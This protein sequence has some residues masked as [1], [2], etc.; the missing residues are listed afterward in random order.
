MTM[1]EYAMYLLQMN[2]QYKS[3][4][5]K[6]IQKPKQSKPKPKLTRKTFSKK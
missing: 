5:A 2:E 3:T 4:T 1:E 6:S